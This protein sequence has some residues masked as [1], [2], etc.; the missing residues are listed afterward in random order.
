MG[1]A[2]DGL[3]K[4]LWRALPCAVFLFSS[5]AQGIQPCPQHSHVEVGAHGAIP[6][7]PAEALHSGHGLQEDSPDDSESAS[8]SCV[9]GCNPGSDALLS[10]GRIASAPRSHTVRILGLR[11]HGAFFASAND[12]L[13]PFPQPPPHHSS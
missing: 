8:C 9:D 12:Y 11:D 13:A 1:G 10:S 4:S 5:I 2:I 6:S 3:R 7:A